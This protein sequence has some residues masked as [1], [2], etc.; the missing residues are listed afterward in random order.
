MGA[1]LGVVII[2]AME[3]RIVRGRGVVCWPRF[4]VRKAWA[5]HSSVGFRAHGSGFGILRLGLGWLG[6]WDFQGFGALWFGM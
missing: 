1:I 5:C 6:I 3:G 4:Q 2:N